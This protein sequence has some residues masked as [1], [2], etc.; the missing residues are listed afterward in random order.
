[1]VEHVMTYLDE[2]KGQQKLDLIE[3]LREVTE[4]KVSTNYTHGSES[5]LGG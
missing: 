5:R 2:L 3:T 1:M 4:G